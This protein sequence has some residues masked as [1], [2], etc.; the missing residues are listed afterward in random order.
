MGGWACARTVRIAGLCGASRTASPPACFA[1]HQLR[2][3]WPWSSPP[4]A[5]RWSA[6]R[7]RRWPTA[8]PR[9]RGRWRQ[10]GHT[11]CNWARQPW[12]PGAARPPSVSGSVVRA[13]RSPCP[14][15]RPRQQGLPGGWGGRSPRCGPPAPA[16]A[17][18]CA[19]AAPCYAP[20]DCVQAE[21]LWQSLCPRGPSTRPRTS[22][23]SSP[24]SVRPRRCVAAAQRSSGHGRPHRVSPLPRRWG[25]SAQRRRAR[26]RGERE[27]IHGPPIHIKLSTPRK[28][29]WHYRVALHT[30]MP[31]EQGASL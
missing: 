20:E 11:G 30:I 22:V 15:S 10:R 12:R 17:G 2:P 6:K 29:L 28:L 16:E 31:A 24:V 3:R 1:S 8:T 5:L 21:A 7:C 23:G 4:V 14:R 13:W 9:P 18:A 19:S 25:P 27:Q 26:A